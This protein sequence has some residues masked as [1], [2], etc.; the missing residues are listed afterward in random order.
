MLRGLIQNC[1]FFPF[2]SRAVPICL[3][4]KFHGT[5]YKHCCPRPSMVDVLTTILIR[6]TSFLLARIKYRIFR[7]LYLYRHLT[8]PL[9]CCWV[10]LCENAFNGSEVQDFFLWRKRFVSNVFDFFQR[11]MTSFVNRLFTVSSFESD[12]PLVLDVDGEMGKKIVMPEGIR[13]E[14]PP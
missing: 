11:L 1:L 12:F 4:T 14:K 9:C 3:L 7:S 8:P 2:V 6:F 10:A 13:Y 5:P